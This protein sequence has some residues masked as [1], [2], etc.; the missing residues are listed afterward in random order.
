[1]I[2]RIKDFFVQHKSFVTAA[3]LF[4]I[5]TITYLTFCPQWFFMDEDFG[6]IL[7]AKQC[8]SLKDFFDFLIHGNVNMLSEPAVISSRIPVAAQFFFYRPLTLMM[9]FFEYH[10]FGLNAYAYFLFIIILHATNT[11]LLS[12]L[13]SFI[14]PNNIFIFFYSLLFAFHPMLFGWFGKVDT[15]QSQLALLLIFLCLIA[16]IKSIIL[17]KS[18]LYGVSCLLFFLCLLI[19]ETFIVFPACIILGLYL[20]HNEGRNHKFISLLKMSGGFI[21][22]IALYLALR[23]TAFVLTMPFETPITF[24]NQT[25]QVISAK[26]TNAYSFFYDLFWLQLFPHTACDFFRGLHLWWLYR[27][28]KAIIIITF[29]TFFITNTRK[30]SI[31]SIVAATLLLLWPYALIPYQFGFRLSYEVLPLYVLCLAYLVYFSSVRISSLFIFFG[32][33]FLT[34]IVFVN[35]M[36][37]IRSTNMLTI[38]PKTLTNELI[39]LKKIAHNKLVH[40]PLFIFNSSYARGITQAVRLFDINQDRP[41]YLLRNLFINKNI[42]ADQAQSFIHIE[43]LSNGIRFQSLDTHN[44]WFALD[45]ALTSPICTKTIIAANQHFL[46]PFYLDNIIIY[47]SENNKI[48]DLFIKFEEEYFDRDI[49]VI[50]LFQDEEKAAIFYA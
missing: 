14:F 24:A 45:P 42:T 5:V 38:I 10:L 3:L 25:L 19:K 50:A 27:L 32:Y 22:I 47:R 1:M 13:L 36:H 31:F 16:F 43:K 23:V 11:S 48:F 28:I 44:A 21:T 6:L 20:F 49:V 34:I 2:N 29:M 9:H 37:I 12:Y 15:Q 4:S 46:I 39:Q 17:K 8:V 30:K 40:R 26:I 41:I 18:Y 33:A 7:R 35:G